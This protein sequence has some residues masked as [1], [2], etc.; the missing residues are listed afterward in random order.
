[1]HH[2]HVILFASYLYFGG[3]Q[4]AGSADAHKREGGK[5]EGETGA[6]P[7]PALECDFFHFFVF[8]FYIFIWGKEF[9]SFSFFVCSYQIN[10]H[11]LL[12]HMLFFGHLI[13]RNTDSYQYRVPSY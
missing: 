5:R 8:L 10:D 6:T 7:I 2:Y 11:L 4:S 13:M 3:V 9:V 1:M 12:S